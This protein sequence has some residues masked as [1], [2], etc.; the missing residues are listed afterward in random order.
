M[1]RAVL[2]SIQYDK[3]YP[4]P[5]QV[6]TNQTPRRS[7]AQR[8]ELNWRNTGKQTGANCWQY[9]PRRD[10]VLWIRSLESSHPW[11]ISLPDGRVYT[12]ILL[13]GDRQ[14]LSITIVWY[15]TSYCCCPAHVV[16]SYKSHF[17]AKVRVKLSICWKDRLPPLFPLPV[18][19]L[20]LDACNFPPKL[21]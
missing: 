19:L 4:Q 1:T 17:H 14:S 13:K 9:L 6:L 7:W 20:L 11:A 10:K 5:V 15:T 8:T 18:I 21:L 2:T 3:L 12:S 16:L